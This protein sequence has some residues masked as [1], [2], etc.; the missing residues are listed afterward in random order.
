MY[1]FDG[2]S[3][4]CVLKPPMFPAGVI[5]LDAPENLQRGD[6]VGRTLNAAVDEGSGLTIIYEILSGNDD[7]IFEIDGCSGQLI[8]AKAELDFETPSR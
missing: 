2:T 8:L 7:G 1:G 5:E 4:A 3:I 6:A